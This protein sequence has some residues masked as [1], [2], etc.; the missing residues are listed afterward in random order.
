MPRALC[1][2]CQKHVNAV[3]DGP[4]P[5][6]GAVIINGPYFDTVAT[7]GGGYRTNYCPDCGRQVATDEQIAQ[8]ARDANRKLTLLRF[9]FWAV[10][11]MLVT[12]SVVGLFS[13]L[14]YIRINTPTEKPGSIGYLAYTKGFKD[15]KLG[16]PLEKYMAAG[17]NS[18]GSVHEGL[19]LYTNDNYSLQFNKYTLDGLRLYFDANDKLLVRVE[20]NIVFKDIHNKNRLANVALSTIEQQM[21]TIEKEVARLEDKQYKRNEVLKT[22][23][24]NYQNYTNAVNQVKSLK[25][26]TSGYRDTSEIARYAARANNALASWKGAQQLFSSMPDVSSEL[27]A[28]TD[29]R[30][31]LKRD[32]KYLRESLD[33]A[34]LP[35]TQELEELF[36]SFYGRP[37]SGSDYSGKSEVLWDGRYVSLHIADRTLRIEDKSLVKRSEARS[38]KIESDEEVERDKRKQQELKLRQEEAIKQ[39][40]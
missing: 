40:L 19:R 26:V 34:H 6:T 33:Y 30:E 4:S 38:R 25:E 35:S 29:K 1:P 2:Y 5:P 18:A 9:I 24:D 22:S 37:I 39:K 28:A 21:N 14:R 32:E 16:E 12:G 7:V 27:K 23:I 8:S 3:S 15:A 11:I 20:G 17:F 10:A 31:N 13:Y 36:S